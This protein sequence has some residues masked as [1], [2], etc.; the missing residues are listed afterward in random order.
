M[1]RFIQRCFTLFFFFS[2]L[3]FSTCNESKV[4]GQSNSSFNKSINNQVSTKLLSEEIKEEKK[5][6][7]FIGVVNLEQK[8]KKEDLNVEDRLTTKKLLR[9]NDVCNL[10]TDK[11]FVN[12]NKASMNFHILGKKEYLIE[13]MCQGGASKIGY[14]FYYYNEKKL[15]PTASLLKFERY[16]TFAESKNIEKIIS[17]NLVGAATFL[18]KTKKLK[19][20]DGSE[21]IFSFKNGKS[22]LVELSVKIDSE[23]DRWKKQNL[24]KLKRSVTKTKIVNAF[25]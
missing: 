17:Y 23:S 11:Y 14:L 4:N 3:A 18:S 9:W 16:A 8:L 2:L 20:Y 10:D 24:K 25:D 7:P 13:V 15:P 21:S 5:Q 19:F 1:N 12:E 6:K 22:T